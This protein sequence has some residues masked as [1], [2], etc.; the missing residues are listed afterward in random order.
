M[1]RKQTVFYGVA[2]LKQCS[3]QSQEFVKFIAREFWRRVKT[4]G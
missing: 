2:A 1:D 3:P 4:G